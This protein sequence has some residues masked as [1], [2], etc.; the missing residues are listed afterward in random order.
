M[1]QRN[2]FAACR[3]V[4]TLSDY[5]LILLTHLAT[6]SFLPQAVTLHADCSRLRGES[7]TRAT[8]DSVELR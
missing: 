3:D 6:R 5:K 2:S 4:L 1:L 7:G 8:A